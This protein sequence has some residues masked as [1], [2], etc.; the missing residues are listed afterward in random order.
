MVKIQIFLIAENVDNI[1][2]KSIILNAKIAKVN[3]VRDALKII[4]MFQIIL[5]HYVENNFL[6]EE[7]I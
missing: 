4:Q 2:A 6:E 7:E 1:K 5:V 3:F